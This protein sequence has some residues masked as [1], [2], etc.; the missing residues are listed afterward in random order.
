MIWWIFRGQVVVMPL[1]QDPEY[2]VFT[3][4]VLD[5]DASAAPHIRLAILFDISRVKHRC[6]WLESV[7]GPWLTSRRDQGPSVEVSG[8]DVLLGRPILLF[9]YIE[10]GCS[11]RC[12][13]CTHKRISAGQSLI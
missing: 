13:D 1:R 12:R 11:S 2:G 7:P 9:V 4:M 6:L 3:A 10:I 8:V 5:D